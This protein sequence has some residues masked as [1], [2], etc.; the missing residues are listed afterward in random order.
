MKKNFRCAII[1]VK[2]EVSF[3]S[4]KVSILFKNVPYEQTSAL[5][6]HI[7]PYF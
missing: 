1:F 3:F 7:F 5:N 6:L 4:F 2:N